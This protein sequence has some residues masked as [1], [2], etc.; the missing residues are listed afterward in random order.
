MGAR[1]APEW[2]PNGARLNAMTERFSNRLD[3]VEKRIQGE[4]LPTDGYARGYL[5]TATRR[6]VCRPSSGVLHG[7]HVGGGRPYGRP[8]YDL[9]SSGCP[10]K[11]GIRLPHG[12]RRNVALL[13]R[14]FGFFFEE[15]RWILQA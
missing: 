15:P 11:V 2:R 3:E 14:G 1:Q 13:L 7:V 5:K 6:H 9:L 10:T 4:G 12:F 8:I